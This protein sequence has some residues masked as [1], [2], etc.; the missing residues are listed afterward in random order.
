M[1]GRGAGGDSNPITVGQLPITDAEASGLL[2]PVLE[3]DP[4]E[5]QPP[6][7]TPSPTSTYQGDR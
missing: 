3:V 7:C 5:P 6:V 4:L 2:S 1:R